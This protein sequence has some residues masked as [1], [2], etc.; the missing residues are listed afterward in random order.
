M[1]HNEDWFNT[2]PEMQEAFIQN[3][4]SGLSFALLTPKA[5]HHHPNK[6]VIIPEKEVYSSIL[7]LTHYKSKGL[8][9]MDYEDTDLLVD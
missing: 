9:L 2:D 3:R 4:T 1:I 6:E 8:H 7:N 5:E